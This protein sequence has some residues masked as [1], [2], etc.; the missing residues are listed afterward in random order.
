[1]PSHRSKTRQHQ[2]HRV[3]QRRARARVREANVAALVQLATSNDKG[4]RGAMQECVE[5]G[6]HIPKP[7]PARKEK[8]R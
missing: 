4:A 7:V 3:E 6:I 1:M 2:P 5:R 8:K